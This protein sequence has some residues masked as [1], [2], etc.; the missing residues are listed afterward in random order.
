MALS[1]RDCLHSLEAPLYDSVLRFL[2]LEDKGNLL[3]Y[4]RENK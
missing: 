1:A 3:K 2:C 4:R